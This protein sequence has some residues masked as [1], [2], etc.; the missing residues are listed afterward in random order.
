MQLQEKAGLREPEKAHNQ[1][2]YTV[3]N[4]LR[5][6]SSMNK[7]TAKIFLKLIECEPSNYPTSCK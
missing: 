1:E 2:D 7:D 4:S 6:I 3:L 5:R